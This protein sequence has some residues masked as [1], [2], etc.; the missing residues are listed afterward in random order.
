M[1]RADT[2]DRCCL[3]PE[4][5]SLRCRGGKP[6]DQLYFLAF[7]FTDGPLPRYGTLIA[8]VLRSQCRVGKCPDPFRYLYHRDAGVCSTYLRD[9][10]PVYATRLHQA[11]AMEP[12]VPDP[13]PG[14]T[15][16]RACGR[17]CRVDQTKRSRPI[18]PM[19]ADVQ[20]LMI[21]HPEYSAWIPNDKTWS[22]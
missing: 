17:K 8:E 1:L 13:L 19:M 16:S 5:P 9:E 15:A 21:K 11:S 10:S 7:N 18:S 2:H 20:T 4:I 6:R 22:D 3:V 12:P 14:D